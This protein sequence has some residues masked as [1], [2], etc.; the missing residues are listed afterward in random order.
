MR[1][2]NPADRRRQRREAPSAPRS[3]APRREAERGDG[4]G[5]ICRRSAPGYLFL[6]PSA[7]ILLV[8]VV[9]PIAQ[10]FWMSLHDWSFFSSSHPLSGSRTTG[11]CGRPPVLERPAQHRDLHGGRCSCPGWR[12]PG[13]GCG[14][15]AQHAHQQVLPAVYFFPVISALATM[16]IVWKFLLDPQ[17]G[18]INHLMVSVGLPDIDFL[19]STTWALARRDRRRCLE[20]RRVL[21]GDLPGRASGHPETLIEAAVLDGAGPWP[22]FRSVTLPHAAAEHAVRVRDRHD[23]VHAALRPGLRDDRRRPALPHRHAGHLPVPGRVPGLPSRL[24]RRASPGSCSCSSCWSPC[25]SCGCSGSRR[26]TENHGHQMPST[27]APP[28]RRDPDVP[29]PRRRWRWWRALPAGTKW[30]VLPAG[31]VITVLPFLWMLG[32]S[33]KPES[34]VFGYP[35]GFS[36]PIQ[37]S[38]LR[39]HLAG[40]AVP[41][42]DRQLRGLRRRRHGL[43][44]VLRL[45]GRVRPLPAPLPRPE[46][47]LLPRAGHPDGARSR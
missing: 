21:H 14:A 7:A 36:Q 44:R 39:R 38:Q 45:P 5:G 8:F 2:A 3:A 40:P 13:P 35:F 18:I 22:R 43:L 26:P 34:D 19:Q 42:A 4:S 11:P 20:E 28:A 30:V 31:A 17:I 27:S 24:R 6:L 12:R 29:Y 46:P 32:T 10:S 23:H 47:R 41:A 33:F 16:G 15:A 9:Y 1:A 25:S 37:R